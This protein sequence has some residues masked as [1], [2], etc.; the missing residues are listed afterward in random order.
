MT[1]RT[2]DDATGRVEPIGGRSRPRGMTIRGV[3]RPALAV[4]VLLGLAAC[5]ER[6]AAA[7]PS[8]PTRPRCA[9]RG[10]GAGAPGRVH[11]RLRE[12]V[13]DG[14]PAAA[15]QRLRRRA[16]DLRGPCRG[17]LSG[18][19]AAQ[20]AGASVDPARCRTSSTTALAAGVA[21]TSDLGIP[22]VADAP[23]TRFTLVTAARPTSARCTRSCESPGGRRAHRRTRRQ[24]GRSSATSSTIR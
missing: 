10:R 16:G 4:A 19:G 23:S 14:R 12:P 6:G 1:R 24:P 21:E 18:T 22:P 20:P 17:D 5:G 15:D 9:G 3:L 8:P 2:D 11:R 13:G 7:T